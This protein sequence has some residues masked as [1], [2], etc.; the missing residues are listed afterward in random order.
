M[1][2]KKYMLG[3]AIRVT[4]LRDADII[5][6]NE[7]V[8]KEKRYK[9]HDFERELV[10]RSREL[11]YSFKHNYISGLYVYEVEYK[12]GRKIYVKIEPELIYFGLS[13]SYYG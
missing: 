8:Y 6:L 10:R 2:N 7:I 5:F 9:M 12:D 13:A 11:Y 4:Q 3:D 1:V